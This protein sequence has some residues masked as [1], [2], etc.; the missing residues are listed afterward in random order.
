MKTHEKHLTLDE[1][2][3]EIIKMA[4]ESGVQANY[5]F[6]TTFDR[7]QTQLKILNGLKEAIEDEGMLVSKEYVKGRKNVYSNPAISDFNRTTDSA[8]KTVSTLM[9]IIKNFGTDDDA[10]AHDPLLEAIN[11]EGNE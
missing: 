9:R 5:F 7:Y 1:Q 2:A 11:G 3:D 4:E 6:I 8:N 10:N